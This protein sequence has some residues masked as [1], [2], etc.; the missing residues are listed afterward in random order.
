M[1]ISIS[2]SRT[3]G[4]A[5]FKSDLLQSKAALEEVAGVELTTFRAPYFSADRCDPWFGEI[6]SQCGFSIDS[7][8]RL[9]FAPPGFS[10]L[11]SLPGSDG[12]VREIPL[13]G[14]GYGSKRITVIGGTYLSVLVWRGLRATRSGRAPGFH[15]RGLPASLRLDPCAEPLDLPMIGSRLE[16]LGDKIRHLGRSGVA[17]KLRALSRVYEFRSIEYLVSESSR[18]PDHQRT[19]RRG[20]SR[21]ND[22][23]LCSA[24]RRGLVVS[25]VLIMKYFLKFIYEIDDCSINLQGIA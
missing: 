8:R 20:R 9:P 5:A 14:L 17:E 2:G 1:A 25:L 7:S 22:R 21:A 18:A 12:S 23:C 3:M 10:G 11:T 13:L 19:S 6:L 24:G 16:R 15:P 4:P